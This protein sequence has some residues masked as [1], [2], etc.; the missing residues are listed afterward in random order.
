METEYCLLNN[1]AFR[2]SMVTDLG[3]YSQDNDNGE[4]NPSILW[5]A[6]KAIFR[7]KI[8]ARTTH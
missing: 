4:V 7:G 1:A 6:A 2:S 3:L 8:M 5:D